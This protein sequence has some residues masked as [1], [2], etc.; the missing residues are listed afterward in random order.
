MKVVEI[1]DSFQGEGIYTGEPATFLRLGGCN[2]NCDFCDTEFDDYKEIDVELVKECLLNH[3]KNHKNK[4]LVI[5]GGEPL[6]HY[7][8]IKELVDLLHYQI[9]NEG[10]KIQ[11]ETNGFIRRIPIRNTTYVISPKRDIDNVFKFYKDY[12]EAYFKF[13][14]EDF[15]DLRLVK[16]LQEKYDYKK[17][18]WLQPEFSQTDRVTRLILSKNIDNI[19]ISGQL[20]KYMGVE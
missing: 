3:I 10:L 19:R 14:I 16:S 18:V 1:F 15:W 2:L 9:F 20:H 6:L 5:T 7:D 13:V 8:E 12:D 4:L 11:I 17:T